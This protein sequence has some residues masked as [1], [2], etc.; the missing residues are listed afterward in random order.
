MTTEDPTNTGA[1][2][3]GSVALWL[4]VLAPLIPMRLAVWALNEIVPC[5]LIDSDFS[6][7]L[8]Q[9]EAHAH[10]PSSVLQ[11]LYA[12]GVS[13]TGLVVLSAV[14]IA[15]SARNLWTV[16]ATSRRSTLLF[17]AGVVSV[18]V[19]ALVGKQVVGPDNC[20]SYTIMRA[21]LGTLRLDPDIGDVTSSVSAVFAWACGALAAAGVFIAFGSV[22]LLDRSQ[23]LT[24]TVET[25]LAE[26][27]SRLGT[28]MVCSATLLTVA[29]VAVHLYFALGAAMF[30]VHVGE[31]S[32]EVI[33][34][35][36][37]RF[38][39]LRGANE[40]YWGIIASVMLA[41]IYLPVASILWAY[42]QATGAPTTD[43]NPILTLALRVIQI[44]SP[45]LTG[46][47]LQVVTALSSTVGQ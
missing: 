41:A 1:Q 39:H 19:L 21:T 32:A 27:Q 43:K 40:L 23:P 2:A 36:T 31:P 35:A 26:R 14:A 37:D 15:V 22:A 3:G 9:A 17:L 46:A 12:F 6:A 10:I 7:V 38:T 30:D 8:G 24:A 44:L 42:R 20:F 13:I 25:D 4:L 16:P 45:L 5:S 18:A 11:G 29:L 33:K 47:L 28:L 34:A